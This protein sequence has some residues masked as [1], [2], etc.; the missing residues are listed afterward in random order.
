MLLLL[1]NPFCVHSLVVVTL[2]ELSSHHSSGGCQDLVVVF[3]GEFALEH[4]TLHLPSTR[5]FG[6]IGQAVVE[7]DAQGKVDVL[8][9]EGAGLLDVELVPGLLDGDLQ[10]V[11]FRQLTLHDIDIHFLHELVIVL[12][13]VASFIY[14]IHFHIL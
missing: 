5:D 8:G 3:P 12:I 10:V 4:V 6:A 1:E 7:E 13:A 14:F 2:Y 11:V 9:A